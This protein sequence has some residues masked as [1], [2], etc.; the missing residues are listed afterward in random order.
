[1]ARQSWIDPDTNEPLIDDYAR[2]MEGML[3]AFED[4]VISDREISDQEARLID[5]MKEIE[6]TLDDATH[7]AVTKLLCE[8]TAWDLMQYTYEMQQARAVVFRG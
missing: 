3:R 2:R 6:P 1:M 8:L 5:L 7:A 4:D